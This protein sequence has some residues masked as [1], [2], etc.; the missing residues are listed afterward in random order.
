[1]FRGERGTRSGQ[2]P[3]PATGGHPALLRNA[4][5]VGTGAILLGTGL[6]WG[7][8]VYSGRSFGWSAWNLY[9]IHWP[10]FTVAI[11][12]A[13]CAVWSGAVALGRPEMH[14]RA[15]APAVLLA[16]F[17]LFTF[18]TFAFGTWGAQMRSFPGYSSSSL[19]IG[20]WLTT[21]GT[22]LVGGAAV[23][24]DLSSPRHVAR[25]IEF[26]A[27]M[28]LLEFTVLNLSAGAVVPAALVVGIGSVV[29]V[30][31]RSESRSRHT[32]RPLA[33]GASTAPEFGP[34][35]EGVPTRPDSET[36]SGTK[37]GEA[38]PR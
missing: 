2:P 26:W 7:V 25:R 30:A 6:P 22:V 8:G 28:A 20:F 32:V 38:T 37:A 19:G 16:G 18:T 15:I 21:A 1:M 23:A 9:Y 36:L 17:V 12:P 24:A 29:Y 13:L 35:E 4:I 3:N 5:L 10:N 27:M 11:V 34:P 14:R 31:V 33:P